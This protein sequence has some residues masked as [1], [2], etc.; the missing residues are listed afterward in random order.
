MNEFA[1]AESQNDQKKINRIYNWSTQTQ[2]SLPKPNISKMN[3]DLTWD[4]Q[5]HILLD[6]LKRNSNAFAHFFYKT[7]WHFSRIPNRIND[8]C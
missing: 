7:D 5:P 3:S 4:I 1:C 8:Y 6:I 2:W